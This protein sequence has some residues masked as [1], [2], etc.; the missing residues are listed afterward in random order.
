MRFHQQESSAVFGHTT[1]LDAA[2]RRR[3]HC[4]SLHC[5]WDV[6]RSTGR[7]LRP[8]NEAGCCSGHGRAWILIARVLTVTTWA[9]AVANHWS[10]RHH[11]SDNLRQP[12]Q[13]RL[14]EYLCLKDCFNQRTFSSFSGSPCLCLEERRYPNS[15]KESAKVSVASSQR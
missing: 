12:W 9:G 1:N 7:L 10:Q 11:H 2:R 5:G 13:R 8:F 14:K 15:A 4:E 6:H 3:G